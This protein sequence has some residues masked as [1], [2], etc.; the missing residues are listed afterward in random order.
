M[1]P[2][3]RLTADLLASDTAHLLHPFTDF[4]QYKKAPGRTYVRGEGV[5]IIDS[6]GR[7]L[8]DGMSGLWCTNLGYS[9]QTI[10]D[11]ITQQLSELPF[12]NSFFNCSTDATIE[13]AERMT[14]LL[15]EGFNHVFFTNSGS[16]ANDTNIRLVHRYFDL[17]GQPDKKI[18]ISR[19]NAYHGSTIAAASLGGMDGMHNQMTALPYVEHIEQPYDFDADQPLSSEA[20][21]KRA[22]DALAHKID[23]LGADRVAAFIAEPIQGAGGV[24]I[25]PANYWPLIAQICKERGVLLISDEV[26]CGFGRTGNLW[27]CETFDYTPDLITFAKAVTNGYQPLG[28]VGVSD[29]IAEVI[30]TS[31]G[32]FAHG[33]TYSGHPVACAAGVATVSIYQESGIVARVKTD[34]QLKWA[35]A[36][37]S[38]RDHPIVG[39]LKT[40]GMLMG[41]ELV[42]DRSSRERLAPDSEGSLYCRNQAIDGG[43]MVRAV[44]DRIISAPPL[45]ISDEEID[46]LVSRLR[47]A[48]D[49]TAQHY[50]INEH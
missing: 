48:L 17:L 8:L 31:G 23:G 46:T 22:A 33:F 41:L 13:L 10:I 27:G 3:T 35:S 44:G 1:K 9:Q 40:T 6:E 18:F 32:E 43:L 21:G 30:T 12:Y 29:A 36:V 50:G 25:P 11:A 19:K 20:L 14:D 28:G 37:D 34:R 7:E 45:T 2:T 38:L 47:T 39:D 24:I 5:H 26:I 16:E 42:R 4:A 49:Q 15:P